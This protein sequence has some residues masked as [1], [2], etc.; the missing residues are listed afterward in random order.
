MASNPDN[1]GYYHL[2]GT[3]AG[4]AVVLNAAGNFNTIVNGT[5][6]T[7]TAIF[8]D[9][10]VAGGTAA[11]VLLTTITGTPITTYRPEIHTKNGLVA[12]VSGTVD[13]L[14]GVG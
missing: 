1:S 5:A 2:L 13:L 12:V 7:G 9:T 8:Y 14:L 4:T 11:G 3:A 6:T 10:S